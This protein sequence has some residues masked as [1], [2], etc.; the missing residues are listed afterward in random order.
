M[1]TAHV[2][3]DMQAAQEKANKAFSQGD[4][5]GAVEYSQKAL[6]LCSL[7]PETAEFD[8]RRFAASVHASL[9]AAYGRQGKH[10]ESFATANKALIFFDQIGELDAVETGRYLMA[11]VNQGTALATLGCLPAA[12]EALEKA[13]EIF[14]CKGLDPAANRQWLEQ[15]DGNIAAI[16]AQIE[17]QQQG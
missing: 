2:I 1:K 11:Q 10:L 16:K 13:K 14:A 7:L 9:S 4:Y 17:K 5:Q 6:S 8:T 15:V 12:L 3:R